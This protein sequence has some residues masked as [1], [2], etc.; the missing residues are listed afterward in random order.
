MTIVVGFTI[1]CVFYS[2]YLTNLRTVDEIGVSFMTEYDCYLGEIVLE[3]KSHRFGKYESFVTDFTVTLR[4]YARARQ[5]RIVYGLRHDKSISQSPWFR[6]E[7][8]LS[9]YTLD[10][11][12]PAPPSRFSRLRV[13]WVKGRYKLFYDRPIVRF[14][15]QPTLG[16]PA[17][18]QV[19][20]RTRDGN[21][22]RQC[23]CK[24][25]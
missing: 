25:M 23:Y 14:Y 7:P 11:L 9:D 21:I 18:D 2:T 19:R 1:N 10:A 17:R 22:P 13:T 3:K 12:P 8:L 6:I 16:I 15:G 24:K 4:F 5:L 20:N